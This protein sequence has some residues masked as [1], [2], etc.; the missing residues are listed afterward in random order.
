MEVK[1]RFTGE[2]IGEFDIS[3]EADLRGANLRGANLSGANL[4][5]AD[6]YEADLYGANLSGADLYEADLREADLYEAN[7]SGA[8]LSGANL[9]GA[10][11]YGAD[12]RGANLRGADLYEADLREANL[13]GADLYEAD[14]YGAKNIPESVYNQ[15]LIVP[16]GDLIIWKSAKEGIVELLIPAEAKRSNATGRKCRFEFAKDI[17]HFDKDGN[18]ADDIVFHSRWDKNFEYRVGEEIRPDG[19]D[20]DRWNECSNGIHGFLNRREAEN[21]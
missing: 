9:R 14:L 17:A 16:D 12:L 8:N 10:D 3:N 6:L 18:P 19:W 7:L 20:D 13:S 15:T 21:Y 11:L 4:R 1:N 5:G 2:I